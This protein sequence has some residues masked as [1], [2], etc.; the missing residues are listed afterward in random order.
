MMQPC[1]T[2]RRTRATALWLCD[3]D[4]RLQPDALAGRVAEL[5]R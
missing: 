1:H 5:Q 4:A 3:R 2:P